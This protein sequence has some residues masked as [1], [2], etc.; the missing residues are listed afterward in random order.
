MRAVAAELHMSTM[1]LYRYV[2]DRDELERLI[3][4]L[5]LED[6]DL[7]VPADR[8]W[9]ARVTELA[10]RARESVLRHPAAI[11]LLLLHRQDAENSLRWG[12]AVLGVL[13]EAGFEG[14]ERAVAFRTLMSY[15]FGAL[16]V[17]TYGPLD[18]AGTKV[19]A[20]LPLDRFRGLRSPLA[21]HA[22]STRA[23]SSAS[24]SRPLS[25]GCVR[26][27][28]RPVWLS[29]WEPETAAGHAGPA[30]QATRIPSDGPGRLAAPA[31][32]AG[33]QVWLRTFATTSALV[34]EMVTAS[35]AT[36]TGL[37][38][39]RRVPSPTC[40]NRLLPRRRRRRSR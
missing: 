31:G 8:P 15:V 26:P 35:C 22:A 37:L 3:V 5:V 10:N 13:A 12:E 25:G 4:D 28:V 1:G 20:D 32:P 17:Q 21:P 23:R 18:G 34:V 16:Q 24:G 29:R 9:T 14:V 39:T 36:S 27:T 19:L 6:L 33:A 40:P 7:E 30:C 11:P 38:A 2:V